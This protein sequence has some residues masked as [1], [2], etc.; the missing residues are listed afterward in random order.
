MNDIHPFR[1]D[2]DDAT[3]QHIRNRVAQF[4]WHEMPDDGGWGLPVPISITCGNSALDWVD[5]YDWRKHETELNRFAHYRAKVDGIDLHFIHEPGS[6][7]GAVTIDHFAWLAGIDGRIRRYYRSH[8]RILNALV[9]VSTMLSRSL[10]HP[11][12]AS[13]FQAGLRALTDRARWLT[14]CIS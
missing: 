3:L 10:H 12:Q 11:C 8:S 2:V 1:I 14:C 6:G 13:V 4:P 7:A 9:A 5:E